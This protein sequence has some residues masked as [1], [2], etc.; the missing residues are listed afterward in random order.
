MLAFTRTSD[1]ETP[2]FFHVLGAMVL[3]GGMVVVAIAL[4]S[5]WRAEEGNAIV[6]T[7]FAYKTLFYVVLPAFIVMRIGAQWTLSKS[8]FDSDQSWVGIGFLVSDLGAILL[9][10]SLV[11]AGLGLRRRN[12]SSG[13]ASSRIVTIVTLVLLAA[14]V[15]A[16][17]AMTTKPT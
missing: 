6:L 7:R 13:G 11:L 8:P 14:Y 17:W 10:V 16:L 3:V 12:G 4:A 5:A 1:W 2:L 9:L 15:L